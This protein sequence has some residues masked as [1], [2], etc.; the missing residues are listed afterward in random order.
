MGWLGF[1]IG[2]GFRT[3]RYSRYA[4]RSALRSGRRGGT[5]RPRG[6]VFHHGYCDINH[7]TQGAVDRCAQSARYRRV[8]AAAI[9]AE[10]QRQAEA[11]YA[12]I[13]RRVQVAEQRAI[14]EARRVLRERRR[15]ELWRKVISVMSLKLEPLT[16]VELDNTSRKSLRVT[17]LIGVFLGLVLSPL[18]VESLTDRDWFVGIL[19]AVLAVSAL[20]GGVIMLLVTRRAQS[21]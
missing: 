14:A 15:A 5:R 4:V 16:L 9:T 6:P 11:E 21:R 1:G 8:E 10:R 17:G 7:R 2:M 3:A 19:I 13:Q 18:C 20:V 12:A